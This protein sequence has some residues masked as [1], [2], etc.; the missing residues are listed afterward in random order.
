MPVLRLRPP[1]PGENETTSPSL[2]PLEPSSSA[3][4]PDTSTF[5]R[6]APT[7][8]VIATILLALFLIFR[9]TRRPSIE[10]RPR[11]DV[12]PPYFYTDD[13]QSLKAADAPEITSPESYISWDEYPSPQLP[14]QPPYY[15]SDFASAASPSII[16]NP[17]AQSSDS[18]SISTSSSSSSASLSAALPTPTIRRH[19]YP[20]D[21]ANPEMTETTRDGTAEPEPIL[22]QENIVPNHRNIRLPRPW[23]PGRVDTVAMKNGCR[24]HVMVL[25]GEPFRRGSAG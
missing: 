2:P 23:V 25:D 3:Q 7:M 13:D 17:D 21:S 1:G 8:F 9:H 5:E 16:S 6:Q 19:S 22:E 12:T 20:A 24:R 14:F 15:Q 4:L 10:T 18:V 11:H